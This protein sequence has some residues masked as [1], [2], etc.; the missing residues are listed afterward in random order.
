[1]LINAGDPDQWTY[2]RNLKKT[3]IIEV[4]EGTLIQSMKLK[5]ED[6]VG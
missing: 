6:Q 5:D 1:M 2:L 4:L 3:L